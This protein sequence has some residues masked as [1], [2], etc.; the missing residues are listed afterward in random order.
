MKNKFVVGEKV[1]VKNKGT[2]IAIIIKILKPKF[3]TLLRKSK[4]L[5]SIIET[6]LSG[7]IYCEVYYVKKEKQLVKYDKSI[8]KYY[9]DFIKNL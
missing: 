7:T 4:Y 3:F 6:N 8:D 9:K 2:Q 1:G 5:V